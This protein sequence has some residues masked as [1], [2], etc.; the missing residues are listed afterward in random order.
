M[1]RKRA[2]QPGKAAGL[3]VG[4]VSSGPAPEMVH[5]GCDTAQVGVLIKTADQKRISM[6][7]FDSEQLKIPKEK[8]RESPCGPVCISDNQNQHYACFI[9][10]TPYK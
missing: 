9:N 4:Q 6:A 8:P 3:E 10:N 2:R 1:V 5:L 7:Q